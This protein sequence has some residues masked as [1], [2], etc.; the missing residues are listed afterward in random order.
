MQRPVCVLHCA[1]NQL[2]GSF[3]YDIA[4]SRPN[5]E[6]YKYYSKSLSL[7]KSSLSCW[8]SPHKNTKLLDL[9]FDLCFSKILHVRIKCGSIETSGTILNLPKWEK[10]TC[11][12]WIILKCFL[13]E[14]SFVITGNQTVWLRARWFTSYRKSPL[15]SEQP[16][17]FAWRGNTNSVKVSAPPD[18]LIDQ[19]TALKRPKTKWWLE[20]R[21]HVWHWVQ[22]HIQKSNGLDLKVLVSDHIVVMIMKPHQLVIVTSLAN[23]THSVHFAC[24]ILARS[25][26]CYTWSQP[27]RALGDREVGSSSTELLFTSSSTCASL[28][29]LKFLPILGHSLGKQLEFP[30][31]K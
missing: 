26:N 22:I 8:A 24:V 20:F 12:M 15:A 16:M 21:G 7:A 6:Y 11:N 31:P 18:E 14:R 5:R 25:G 17:W 10:Q 23:N 28:F 27:C 19:K 13:F 1:L 2:Q 29:F 3:I 4:Q 30:T 9:L